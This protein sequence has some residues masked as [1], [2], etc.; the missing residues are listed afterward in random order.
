MQ[1]TAIQAAYGVDPNTTFEEQFSL[2][3]FENILFELIAFAHF[4]I[5]QIFETHI[6]EVRELLTIQKRHRAEDVRNRLLNFQYGFAIKPE[7]DEF[8][9]GTATDD[10]IAASKIIKYAAVTESTDEKRVICKIATENNAGELEPIETEEMEALSAYVQA[11]KPAGVPYTVLNLPPDRLQLGIRIFRDPLLLDS[12]GVH[13]ISGKEVVKDALK[14]F[15]KNMPFNGE[16]RMQDL[17][18]KLEQT[19]G[20][21]LVQVD[22][23]LTAWLDAVGGGYGDFTAID[24][25][26]IPESGYFRIENGN[27]EE[28]F[29]GIT[30]VV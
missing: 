30:Y 10:E 9:N 18:N 5:E 15:L 16:L 22:Y 7:T 8:V 14:D 3:S 29:S 2:I 12:N 19:E 24:V 23:A 25:R 27:G 1:S 21:N 26:K 17:A 4:V 28:D 20:V 11:I 13:R 6:S